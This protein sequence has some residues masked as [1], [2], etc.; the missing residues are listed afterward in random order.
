MK[1]KDV[2]TESCHHTSSLKKKKSL[3]KILE[4]ESSE[5]FS[6]L[7]PTQYTPC[8]DQLSTTCIVSASDLTNIFTVAVEWPWNWLAILLLSS[9]HLIPCLYIMKPTLKYH[10]SICLWFWKYGSRTLGFLSHF[11]RVLNV[12]ILF[13]IIWVWKYFW[14]SFYTATNLEIIHQVLV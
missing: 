4:F 13:I 11:H 3:S 12:K 1:T 6:F 10:D 2:L 7:N 8:G 9:K 14:L 5:I